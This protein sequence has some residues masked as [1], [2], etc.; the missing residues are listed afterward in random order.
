MSR[1]RPF[2]QHRE[3]ARTVAGALTTVP[4]E[5]QTWLVVDDEG[6]Q[7]GPALEAAGARVRRWWRW[8]FG[9]LPARPWPPAGRWQGVVLRLPRDRS[10]LDMQLHLLCP[11]LEAGGRLVAWGANDEGARSAGGVLEAF[12]DQVRPV[13]SRAHG[14]VFEAR[15]PRPAEHPGPGAPWRRR[16]PVALPLGGERKVTLDFVSYPGVFA[17]GGLDEGTALLC[18]VLGDLRLAGN[19]LDFAC[20]AGMIAAAVRRLCPAATITGLEV[21]ALALEAAALNVPDAEWLLSDGWRALPSQRRFDQILSNPPV[22][23]GREEDHSIL[24]HLLT[25][26]RR[27]LHGG[28]RLTLV[29][30]GR[31]GALVRRTLPRARRLAATAR[32]QVWQA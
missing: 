29:V 23:R 15:R 28:G 19:V 11:T 8:A 24:L 22:H 20:G 4:L 14:R 25:R 6:D 17:G 3:L 30:Q 16:Q 27:Y 12:F 9:G 1:R 13:A 32:Y 7:L 21:D 31:L 5:G 18:S 26:S 2:E 10:V